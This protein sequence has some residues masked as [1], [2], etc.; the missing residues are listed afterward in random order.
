MVKINKLLNLQK[1]LLSGSV[2]MSALIFGLYIIGFYA[3]SFALGIPEVWNQKL[4]GLYLADRPV[5]TAGIGIHFLAGGIILVLGSIQFVSVLRL[6]HPFTHRFLGRIYVIACLL[7]SVGGLLFVF[8]NGTIGGVIMDIA[9]GL[10]GILLF[11]C[12]IQTIRFAIKRN[13]PIHKN[14]SLRLYSLAIGSWF[15]RM[16]YGFWF[17]V[18]GKIGHTRDFTGS[19]DI[20]M[21]FFFFIPNL[22]IAELIIR[23]FKLENFWAKTISLIFLCSATL[24]IWLATYFFTKKHWLSGVK[25][26]INYLF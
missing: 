17:L 23:E 26:L 25:S 24:Y 13:I 8:T 11:I 19:F 7:A 3:V 21:N 14:W 9:F 10:Y 1:K 20:F 18:F 5:A 15:Y 2:W 6:K 12:A 16:G 4:P 22:I